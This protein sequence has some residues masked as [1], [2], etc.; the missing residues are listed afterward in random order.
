MIQGLVKGFQEAGF[1]P[2]VRSLA[3]F[4]DNYGLKADDDEADGEDGDGEEDGE[5]EDE[6]DDEE[7]DS[8]E[9]VDGEEK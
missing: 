9:S 3:F 1:R 6:E 8:E 4:Q 2:E 7:G 5:E